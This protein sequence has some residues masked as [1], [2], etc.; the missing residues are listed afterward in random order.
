MSTTTMP[1]TVALTP[2]LHAYLLAHGAPVDPILD[3][4]ASRTR[5]LVP[6]QAHMLLAP[7]EGTLLTFLARLVGARNA[8]EVGTFTGYSSICLARG[9]VDG[10]KLT[11]CDV[12]T[13]WTDVARDYWSRAGVADR[14]ELRIAP[15][16]DTLRSLPLGQFLDLAFIDADKPGYIGYWEEVVRRLRPG[17]LVIVDNTLFGGQVVHPDPAEKPAAIR[18]FNTHAAADARVELVM[19]PLADGVTLGRRVA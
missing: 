2:E 10:G 14:V 13:E 3:D 19:L 17:G 7:E 1:K 4:L 5:E 12:S 15:A 11:T 18:A 8:I 6:E 9:L 16:I